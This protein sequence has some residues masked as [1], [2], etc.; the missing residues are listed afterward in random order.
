VGVV[1]VAYNG[2]DDVR[3]C[4][5]SLACATYPRLSIV[6]VDN[7]SSD[8]TADA[9]RREF[10]GVTVLALPENCGFTGGNNVGIRWCLEHGC[11]A[12]LLLNS[13]TR[14]EP[15]FLDRMAPHLA[16]CR[17]VAPEIRSRERPE[18]KLD[19]IGW[20]DWARGVAR[21]A[22]GGVGRAGPLPTRIASGCCLLVPRAVFDR[23][24]LLDENFFLYF[25][26][27]DFVVRAQLA[28]FELVQERSAVIYHRESETAADA[29]VSPLKIYYNTRNRL[30][31]MR[32][33]SRV[34][35]PFLGWFVLTRVG[36]GLRYLAAGRTALLVSMVR[37]IRDFLAGRLARAEYHW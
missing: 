26:D 18:R 8:G 22:S 16:R 13:D 7:A 28:G 21:P 24:G 4:L 34:T 27:V 5:R 36:Y 11:D 6:L 9:V 3:S 14:V 29:E 12:V 35:G 32:K 30:Y 23:V 31:L 1:V 20:F 2:L 19:A 33:H 25:E 15:D 37:G 17:V 10:G